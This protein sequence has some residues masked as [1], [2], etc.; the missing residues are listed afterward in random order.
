MTHCLNSFYIFIE[1]YNFSVPLSLVKIE[2]NNFIPQTNI[3]G[4]FFGTPIIFY[5]FKRFFGLRAVCFIGEDFKNAT[6]KIS[7]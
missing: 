4:F 1:Y 5:V 6:H 7:I 2:V 3:T